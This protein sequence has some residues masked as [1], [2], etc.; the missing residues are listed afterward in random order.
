MCRSLG[1]RN[2]GH[3]LLNGVKFDRI[4]PFQAWQSARRSIY[5][6]TRGPCSLPLSHR[7]STPFMLSKTLSPTRIPGIAYLPCLQHWMHFLQMVAITKLWCYSSYFDWVF[8]APCLHSSYFRVLLLG[9]HSGS[10]G[11]WICFWTSDVASTEL[12]R[13][14]LLE[15][16]DFLSTH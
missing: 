13:S 1:K 2:D 9:S 4:W 12:S 3:A 10:L 11:E 5:S 8:P 14:F 6:E 16:R 7:H 15:E